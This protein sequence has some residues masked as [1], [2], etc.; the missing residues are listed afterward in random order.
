[1]GYRLVYRCFALFLAFY[2]G[3]GAVGE[4]VRADG[5]IFLRPYKTFEKK[6][7]EDEKA[8]EDRKKSKSSI[9]LR[10]QG[11]LSRRA[12][13]RIH[14]KRSVSPVFRN[15]LSIYKDLKGLDL[16]KLTPL[17][18]NPETPEE[19]IQIAAAHRIPLVKDLLAMQK[20]LNRP[21]R[22]PA[23]KQVPLTPPPLMSDV[24]VFANL[25]PVAEAESAAKNKNVKLV[26]KKTKKKKAKSWLLFRNE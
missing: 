12:I 26:Y 13:A 18:G 8:E 16:A 2:M 25:Q 6:P 15:D 17:G 4:A 9:F 3:F 11:D 24:R 10:P 23:I 19:L 22:L 1:M 5:P 21:T 20:N 7:D 14:P